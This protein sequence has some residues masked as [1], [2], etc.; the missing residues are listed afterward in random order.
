MVQS[1]IDKT[2]LRMEIAEKQ[3]LYAQMQKDN[4][5]GPVR[6]K[7]VEEIG[8]LTEKLYSYGRTK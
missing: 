6:E 1:I 2:S 4:I 7:L 3:R 8:Q 5:T